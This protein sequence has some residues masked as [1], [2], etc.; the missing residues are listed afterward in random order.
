MINMKKLTTPV[1]LAIVICCLAISACGQK[2]PLTLPNTDK[3]TNNSNTE[4]NSTNGDGALPAK[5]TVEA[6]TKT[7][8]SELN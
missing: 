1:Q 5:S 3:P 8:T 4:R 6:V 7:L 2:G